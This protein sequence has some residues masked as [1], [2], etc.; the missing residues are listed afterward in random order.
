MVARSSYRR[1]IEN[2]KII[3]IYPIQKAVNHTKRDRQTEVIYPLVYYPKLPVFGDQ[4]VSGIQLL[5]ILS[6]TAHEQEA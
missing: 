3:Y 5:E 6:C 2:L 4:L 1:K